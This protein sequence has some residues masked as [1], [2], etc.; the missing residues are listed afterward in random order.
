MLTRFLTQRS[1]A[2]PHSSPRMPKLCDP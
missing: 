2:P 1:V